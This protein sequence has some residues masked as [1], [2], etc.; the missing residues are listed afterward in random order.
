V[1]FQI[2]D[3]QQVTL[4]A[5]ALDDEGNPA[6]ATIAFSSSD[7]TVAAVTDNGDGTALLVA[8]PGEGGLGTATVT[9]TVTDLSGDAVITGTFDVEVVAG[10]AVTVN[11][12]PGAPEPKA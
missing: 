4:T 12:T 10:D 3:D 6:A 7:E 2:R 9:A 5:S 11:I 8:S 1:A